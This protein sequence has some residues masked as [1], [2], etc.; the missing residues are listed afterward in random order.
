VKPDDAK[1]VARWNE[2]NRWKESFLEAA[3]KYSA[4]GVSE[5][6][7]NLISANQSEYGWMAYAD[8]Y[9]FNVARHL[10]VISGH[11]GYDD[12][13][14]TYFFPSFTHEMGRA[15]DVNKPCWYMPTWYGETSDQYRLEQYLSFITDIQGMEKPPDMHIQD[16]ARTK[17]A[18]GIVESNKLMAR[19]GTIFTTM[20]PTRG[21]VAV[22][23]SLSQDLH[24]EVRD[25][26]NPKKVGQAAY[27]GGGHV[28]AKM[29]ASYLAGKMIH[30]PFWPVVE[31]DILDGSL[32]ANHKA[33]LIA[34]VNALEPKV[35]L[36]LQGYI[37]SG[38]LVLVSDDSQVTIPGATKLGIAAPD[39][40]YNEVNAIWS[41]DQK[42][43]MQLRRVEYWLKE[44]E[45]YAKAIEGKI[46]AAGIKP[47]MNADS[48]S[49][50]TQRQAQGDIEYL[51]AVNATPKA[52]DPKVTI[53]AAD[54]TLSV[55]ADG[56]PIYD[57]VRGAV[58]GEF[59]PQG[60]QL[61]AKIHFGPG[62]MRVFGRTARPIEA[63]SVA[64]PT[65]FCDF[66]V[67]E[68]PIRIE[69]SAT[70]LDNQHGVL[71]GA[72]PMRL[73]LIDPLGQVR[74]DLY[75]ATDRGSLKIDLPLAA[76][77]PAGKWTLT[78]KELLSGKE[79]TASFNYRPAGQAAALA[80]ETK[81]AV[82]F[83]DDA[84]HIFKLF[85]THQDFTII[86]GAGDYDAA[87]QRVMETLKPWG[88]ECKLMKA[89]DVK[90]HIP[91]EDAARTWSGIGFGRVDLTHPNP[92]ILGFE[93]RGPAILIGTPDDNAVI[94]F[95]EDH[96]F[97]PYPV[98]PKQAAKPAKKGE[99]VATAHDF[100]G[101]GRGYIAWQRDAVS[102]GAES[103]TLI[104]YDSAGIEEAVGSLYEAVAGIDP[105][106]KFTLPAP[107]A[108]TAA[109]KRTAPPQATIAW[110]AYAPDRITSLAIAGD[111]IHVTSEDGSATTLDATGK[112]T[113]TGKA[114]EIA[115]ESATA[116][117]KVSPELAKELVPGRVLKKVASA[118]GLT[119]L[120]YWGG[121]IQIVDDS[122]ATKSLQVLPNDV[123][124]LAW[125]NGKLIV[126]L[127]D[128][129][130]V[131]LEMK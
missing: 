81:R 3:W 115:E 89:S 126:G 23:Y 128:G 21:D 71:A 63:V 65:L 130:I 6:S 112:V 7:P 83:G 56:R 127:A 30:V 4:F 42:R 70:L 95:V 8:G 27:E 123:C 120:G 80:G 17:D 20:R 96:G 29:L 100:P 24:A 108:V 25:M 111:A 104:G 85:R 16:P 77:D 32:A 55:A 38:G 51:F 114:A 74:Y 26:Q 44:V 40:L 57:A 82:S 107:A 117:P 94:K 121:T 119:A 37:A 15:R 43:S 88:A 18:A 86:V 22:L 48:A 125:M 50:V 69:T 110:Q 76:N 61:A 5:V 90:V 64:T 10:P 2:M 102:Y 79:G 52:D 98:S 122:G 35:I 84:D 103:V 14:A 99:T 12:G 106:T 13:C 9:Y 116:I 91:S 75:R 39:K 93:V 72:A 54:A 118:N 49:I 68:N 97:L 101:R 78:V 46:S 19:L 73:Q 36:A 62:A 67:G 33:V 109:S 60:N 34:G 131:A 129:A 92:A 113:S 28:R 47:A 124:D 59:A 1:A 11:G 53:E 105:L 66:T 45:P 58:A 41:T 87:V 31:E